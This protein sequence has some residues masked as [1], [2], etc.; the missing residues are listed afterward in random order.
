MK[1]QTFK[2]PSEA[3]GREGGLETLDFWPSV[4]VCS[5]LGDTWGWL[6]KGGGVFTNDC[7]W[8][9]YLDNTQQVFN[10]YRYLL[11]I[12]TSTQARR[13]NDCSFIDDLSITLLSPNKPTFQQEPGKGAA[14]LNFACLAQMYFL[15]CPVIPTLTDLRCRYV[16]I[17]L[18]T[19]LHINKYICAHTHTHTFLGVHKLVPRYKPIFHTYAQLKNGNVFPCWRTTESFNRETVFLSPVYKKIKPQQISKQSKLEWGKYQARNEK[20]PMLERRK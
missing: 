19:C 12:C 6:R 9:H 11:G 4:Q 3:R 18:P 15:L 5:R 2:L 10:L 16:S 20:T 17:D 7:A 8:L 14:G 1:I 13:R